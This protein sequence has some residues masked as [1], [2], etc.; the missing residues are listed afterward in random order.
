MVD[1]VEKIRNFNFPFE[2]DVIDNVT[3]AEYIWIDG[4]GMNMRSKTKVYH[5]DIKTIED[6]DWWT[7]DGSSC[8][9]ATTKDSEIYLKPVF[10]C[11]DPFRSNKN[12]LVLCET[13]RSD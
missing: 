5:K 12:I 7:F 11:R 8:G 13:Y 9:Q 10:K 4:T 2:Q 1:N 6:L 3:L